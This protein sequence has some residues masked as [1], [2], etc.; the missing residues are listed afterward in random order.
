MLY[1]AAAAE[2][3]PAA[4]RL[5]S[6]VSHRAPC[7]QLP[8]HISCVQGVRASLLWAVHQCIEI[9]H[10]HLCSSRGIFASTPRHLAA[11]I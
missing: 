5:G 10:V 7:R 8:L 2:A 3:R 11:L 9:L 1:A 6:E 4:W